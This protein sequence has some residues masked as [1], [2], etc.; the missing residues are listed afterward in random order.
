[1]SSLAKR[2]LTIL[3]GAPLVIGFLWV[4]T[5][6]GFLILLVLGVGALS[7]M[8]AREFSQLAERSSASIN[9]Q[10]FQPTAFAITLLFTVYVFIDA[11]SVSYIVQAI[12]FLPSLL[13]WLTII[14]LVFWLYDRKIPRF[15]WNAWAFGL[16]YCSWLPIIFFLVLV[17]PA[18]FYYAI[19][20]LALVWAFDIGAYVTG[21][22]IGKHQL[23]PKIS[24]NKTWEGVAGGL[25]LAIL[26]GLG[27]SYWV[28]LNIH[29]E[30]LIYHSIVLSLIVGIT[31]QIGDLII[32]K[33]KRL[34]DVKDSG[35]LLPGHGGLLDRIDGLLLAAP[36]FL[37]YL[38]LLIL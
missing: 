26:A 25:M 37:F 17:L 13:I 29:I 2:I 24:P 27:V 35:S 33:R 36:I 10:I 23:S 34:A 12:Y 16:F 9:P 14:Y 8:I 15:S 7:F 18:G 1:M 19:W 22:L 11:E 30:I 6:G 32:S 5:Q 4:G 28:S 38:T 21:K 3:I 31:S 20:L